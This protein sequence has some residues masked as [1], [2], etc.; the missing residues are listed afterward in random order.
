MSD[1]EF[2]R[3]QR[4]DFYG[5]S[6]YT[7]FGKKTDRYGY[8]PYATISF[9]RGHFSPN[10]SENVHVGGDPSQLFTAHGPHVGEIY[11]D[12]SMSSHV[13]TLLA[14]VVEDAKGVGEPIE[15]SS[16]LSRYSSRLVK[17]GF[18]KELRHGV[19]LVVGDPNNPSADQ[20]NDIDEQWRAHRSGNP[21]E[22]YYG[23]A[24]PKEDLQRYQREGRELIRPNRRR[25][26]K[27]QSAMDSPQFEQLRLDI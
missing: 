12:P 18:E 9:T 23:T 3:L 16:S 25:N 24:Q 2:P 15:A 19:P 26:R 13:P 10:Y 4:R 5:G 8:R 27:V 20:T 14:T 21:R 7:I 22:T 17:K 1:S 6:N 11:A